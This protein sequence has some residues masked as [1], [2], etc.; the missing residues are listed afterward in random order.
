MTADSVPSQ[1]VEI[2]FLKQRSLHS[3]WVEDSVGVVD[4]EGR[5]Q[6]WRKQ[7]LSSQ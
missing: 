1:G 7:S 6:H 4:Y 5:W 3:G 2:D